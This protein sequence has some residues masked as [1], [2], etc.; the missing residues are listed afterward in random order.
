MAPG[1]DDLGVGQDQADKSG[2]SPIVRHLVD[3]EGF[4]FAALD[5][6][7]VKIFLA[8][9]A[10]STGV[11]FQECLRIIASLVARMM[12][13]RMSETLHR[14]AVAATNPTGAPI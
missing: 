12:A 5:L 11:K 14:G 13:T 8:E 3:E 1:I 4:A 9:P 7:A 10:E 6:G 2:V